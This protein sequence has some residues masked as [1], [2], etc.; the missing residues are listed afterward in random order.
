MGGQPGMPHELARALLDLH[1]DARA[2]QRINELAEKNQEGTLTP[3]ERQEFDSY[4]RVGSLIN[5]LQAK[6]RLTL[7]RGA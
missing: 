6:A 5:L 3:S 1:F 4:L 7:R 2:V